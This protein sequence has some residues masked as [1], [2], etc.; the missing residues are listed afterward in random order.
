MPNWSHLCAGQF[1][2]VCGCIN[3]GLGACTASIGEISA[4]TLILEIS[5]HMH[6]HI[7]KLRALK[8]DPIGTIFQ[9]LEGLQ[10]HDGIRKRRMSSPL[11]VFIGSHV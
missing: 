7:P 9:N 8:P 3:T 11:G 5:I 1:N 4:Q 2:T 6:W 10:S